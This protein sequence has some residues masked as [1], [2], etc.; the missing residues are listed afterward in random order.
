MKTRIYLTA[1]IL[2][3]A[4]CLQ[5]QTQDNQRFVEENVIKH[6]LFSRSLLITSNIYNA[7]LP[8]FGTA[9]LTDN[10]WHTLAS[11][12]YLGCIAGGF[13]MFM[14]TED[15][16]TR[17]RGSTN[18][19]EADTRMRD[20]KNKFQTGNILL[21]AAAGIWIFEMVYGN[22]VYQRIKKKRQQNKLKLLSITASPLM[23]PRGPN[24]SFTGTEL[25]L[26]CAF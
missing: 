11:P 6:N 10:N 8:G 12:L 15:A 7:F 17:Y 16:L 24:A 5:A 22:I 1:C 4:V 21:G 25:Q 13:T 14:L 9:S 23:I 26:R 18:F 20:A 2:S 19:E 3:I